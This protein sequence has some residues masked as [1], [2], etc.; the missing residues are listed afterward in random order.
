MENENEGVWGKWE[1][2]V[3]TK[4]FSLSLSLPPTA[5]RRK[6]EDDDDEHE[7]EEEEWVSYIHTNIYICMYNVS[8]TGLC[9]VH[10]PSVLCCVVWAASECQPC[11]LAGCFSD[12]ACLL[13]RLSDSK[14]SSWNVC[15]QPWPCWL[16][17]WPY[18]HIHTLSRHVKE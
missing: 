6:E 10:P 3:D 11:C 17:P 13:G 5:R 8:K 4:R 14:L 18:I 1:G 15:T 12:W 7:E 16:Q 2:S 9:F